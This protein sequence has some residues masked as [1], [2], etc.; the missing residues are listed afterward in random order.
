MYVLEWYAVSTRVLGFVFPKK[1]WLEPG[2]PSERK[3]MAHTS[4]LRH[5]T[6]VQKAREGACSYLHLDP[7]DNVQCLDTAP[8]EVNG[9]LNHWQFRLFDSVEHAL[10]GIG[11]SVKSMRDT[12]AVSSYDQEDYNQVIG[13]NVNFDRVEDESLRRPITNASDSSVEGAGEWQATV[14]PSNWTMQ[15]NVDDW[16][17]YTN[18]TYP[19]PNRPPYV[20]RKNPTGVYRLRFRVNKKN[21]QLIASSGNNISSP[22]LIG[23]YTL[24]FHGVESCVMV[25]LNGHYVGMSKD[26][27]LPSEFDVTD[28]IRT[29]TTNLLEVVVP[30]FCDGSYL[31]DQDHWW[32]AGI[33]RS[34]DLICSP[35]EVRVEN[36][37]VDAN[38]YGD[39]NV[40]VELN[41][42]CISQ[43]SNNLSENSGDVS[44]S[45]RCDVYNDLQKDVL[46]GGLIEGDLI[47]SKTAL[48][49]YQEVVLFQGSI[50]NPKLWSA[51]SPNLYTLV[52]SLV[53]NRHGSNSQEEVVQVES[54][55]IGFRTVRIAHIDS[56]PTPNMLVNGKKIV[57]CGV[58]RHEH[59]PDK[60]K[61]IAL[62][63][64]FQDCC[65]LKQNNFNAVRCSHYPNHPNFYRLADNIGLYIVDEANIE[66]HGIQPMGQLMD[67]PTW[68]KAVHARVLE[69]VFR[70][71]NHPSIV[72][73][74][75][76][77]ESGRGENLRTVL[78]LI[79]EIT[80]QNFV[81][82]Y[83][84]GGKLVEGTGR[85]ELTDVI[86]PMYP[87]V[88]LTKE[89]CTTNDVKPD[90][91][92]MLDRPVILCEY[93]HAM[94]NSNGNLHLYWDMFWDFEYYR[95]F[96][97]KA[98]YI[99]EKYY[100]MFLY[101]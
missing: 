6:S 26:S 96:I 23:R 38:M 17:I 70:D 5:Y 94:G 7:A 85:T 74:S 63:Q 14:V 48:H 46:Q 51:D 56:H 95:K 77:N 58:N 72:A 44:Y 92:Y 99:V 90:G 76:G 86:C 20:P 39:L 83:E 22:N 55:R 62:S 53:R 24:L 33:H 66:T 35:Q 28:A 34:I 73:L 101:Q 65:I 89:L 9:H 21:E 97:N 25:Y 64:M 29:S 32:M 93:S 82:M 36:F 42:S 10:G 88:K 16:P 3:L 40:T 37:K 61:V 8:T 41:G 47:W 11:R 100:N 49:V 68:R 4:A 45:L 54:S 81:V 43:L 59:C 19:F 91:G 13:E 71:Q 79:D 69:Y 50:Q 31:E 57:F 2:I 84:S 15:G 12:I 27:R 1:V 98:L 30:R 75:L 18:V 60:G 87:P 80:L 78:P 52:L 67:D